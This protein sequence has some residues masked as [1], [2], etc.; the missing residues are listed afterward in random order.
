[1]SDQS[2]GTV[3][4]RRMAGYDYAWHH[5]LPSSDSE[6]SQVIVGRVG[7]TFVIT[8]AQRRLLGV[9]L[10]TE[11]MALHSQ[12]PLM[13]FTIVGAAMIEKIG[14]KWVLFSR[15]GKVL[16]THSTKKKARTQE[17]AVNISKA[18]AAGH[19]IPRP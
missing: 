9:G 6:H 18:R 3:G 7:C 2:E 17:R 5:R 13:A 11:E 15:K 10:Y 14:K 16:G 4:Q 1:M 19:R 12:R 8:D